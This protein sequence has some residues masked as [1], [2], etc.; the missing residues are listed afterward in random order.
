MR[1]ELHISNSLSPSHLVNQPNSIAIPL[2][3]K[4]VYFSSNLSFFMV[5]QSCEN[6]LSL[7]AKANEEQED[8][9]E[10]DEEE[11]DGGAVEIIQHH[12]AQWLS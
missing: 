7:V 12:V 5:L 4:H 2:T 3:P 10:I 9:P 6:G 1:S 8:M 11:E